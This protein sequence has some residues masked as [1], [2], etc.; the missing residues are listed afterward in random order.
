MLL[1]PQADALWVS[2]WQRAEYAAYPG[3]ICTLFRN[4]SAWLSSDM[5]CQAVAATRWT[6]GEPPAAG[7]LTFIDATKIRQKRDPGRCFRKAG[8]Q[9]AGHTHKGLLILQLLSAA[10][11]QPEPPEG[12]QL[13]LW[14]SEV[15]CAR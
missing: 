1:T 10:M 13:R 7:M 15:C 11:P 9:E 4:E 3:W 5:I 14:E 6:W 8:F 2:S 12:A